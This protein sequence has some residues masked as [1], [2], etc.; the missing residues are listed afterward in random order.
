VLVAA[1]AVR[2]VVHGRDGSWIKYGVDAQEQQLVAAL[3]PGGSVAPGEPEQAA[4][5]DGARGTRTSTP[6][7][8]GDYPEFYRRVRDAIDGTGGN[9]VPPEQAVAVA[10]VV[11]TAIRSSAE[12]RALTVPLTESERLGFGR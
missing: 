2:F 8:S 12:G 5:V 10:A 4:M 7:P 6:V 9:P 1:P 3:T 11:E